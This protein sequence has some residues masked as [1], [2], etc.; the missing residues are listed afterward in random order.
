MV[1]NRGAFVL[2]PIG[3]VSRA[4]SSSSVPYSLPVSG[5]LTPAYWTSWI[6]AILLLI[7]A[8]GGLQYGDQGLYQADALLLPQFLG[9][10]A[11]ALALAL[12]SLI[13][14]I[15]M[16]QR[17]S[18]RGLVLWAG[19]LMYIAYWYHFYLAGIP[20]G[21]LYLIHV[22]TVSASMM[23]LCIL[24]SRIDVERFAR[25]FP[26]SM[27]VKW[28]GGLM[29]GLAA[30]FATVWVADVVVK[31]MHGDALD[32]VARGVYTVDLTLMLPVTMATGFLLW[33]RHAWGYVLAG[34]L[35]V[36][37][38]ASM[39]TL[40]VTS[41]LVDLAGHPVGAPLTLFPVAAVVML[42]AVVWYFRSLRV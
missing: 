33:R 21:G 12:P 19:T 14:A 15:W 4:A 13:I 18:A 11:L 22:G 20:F 6:A 38:C 36:N 5:S 27:P 23:S 30:V 8:V 1:N 35:L 26:P 16:T 29:T 25:R 32:A 10:D 42:G 7:T 24:A 2:Q 9:Q 3:S 37:A 41:I 17:G 34:P 39:V 40:L 31:T 28:I